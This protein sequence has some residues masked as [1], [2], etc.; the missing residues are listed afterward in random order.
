MPSKAVGIIPGQ[1]SWK[2][3]VNLDESSTWILISADSFLPWARG[4]LKT[5]QFS[6]SADAA[7]AAALGGFIRTQ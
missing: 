5:V 4:R 7:R 1:A 2:E 3:P 6:A